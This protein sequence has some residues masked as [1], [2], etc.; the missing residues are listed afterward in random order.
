MNELLKSYRTN[1]P[2]G[3]WGQ[4]FTIERNS[5]KELCYDIVKKDREKI[6]PRVSKTSNVTVMLLSKCA[7]CNSKRSR[8][9]KKLEAGQLL[10]SLG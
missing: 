3:K 6:N 7:V 8:F 10:S 9:I 5:K 2:E 1:Y 4:H